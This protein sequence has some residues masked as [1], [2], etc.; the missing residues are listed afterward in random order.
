MAFDWAFAQR[1]S[2]STA[3]VFR[4]LISNNCGESWVTKKSYSGLS[5]LKSVESP[6][7]SP[8]TPVDETE[9]NSDTVIINGA[10]NLTDHLLVKF[11]FIG[12]GGNNFY[13]DNI[14]IGHPATL[15]LSIEPETGI[16]VFPNPSQNEFTIQWNQGVGAQ[17]ICL[18]NTSGQVVKSIQIQASETAHTVDLTGISS[19][20]YIVQV[21]SELGEWRIPHTV[22]K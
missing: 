15:G 13:L 19:G 21:K 1:D 2:S 4:V 5:T 3:D 10:S 17:E 14:R 9:W 6:V 20:Y 12:K 7:Y 18:L 22:L 8:F 16:Q 11:Y